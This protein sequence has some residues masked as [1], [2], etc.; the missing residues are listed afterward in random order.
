MAVWRPSTAGPASAEACGAPRRW[1]SPPA[2]E[3]PAKAGRRS[4]TGS[5]GRRG[6]IEEGERRLRA[7]ALDAG[8]AWH[9]RRRHQGVATAGTKGC[10]RRLQSRWRRLLEE[11]VRISLPCP[12]LALCSIRAELGQAEPA[13][14]ADSS[15]A[16][17]H[18]SKPS[19]ANRAEPSSF[20]PAILHEGPGF[21]FFFHM[22]IYSV[23]HIYI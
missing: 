3:M 21:L 23:Q 13:H 7:Q 8:G 16:K 17:P 6:A 5:W 19:R 4:T 14:Q 15:Q 18:A 12:L 11:T 22:L 10:R 2:S 20:F 1:G 9:R